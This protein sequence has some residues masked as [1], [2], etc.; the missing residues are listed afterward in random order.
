MLLKVADV[1]G[2]V[3]H[4]FQNRN[5]LKFNLEKSQCMHM[6]FDRRKS[7]VIEQPLKLK[8]NII[9]N[10]ETYKYLG[11]FKDNKNSLEKTLN[12]AEILQMQ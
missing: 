10:V 4:G 11:D 2:V 1:N 5:L 3:Y 7:K 6:N 9:K 12:I 8:D